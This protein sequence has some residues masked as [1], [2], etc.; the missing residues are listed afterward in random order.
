MS[1]N[2]NENGHKKEIDQVTGVET[3]GHEWDGLKELNNPAPRWWVIVWIICTIW[4]VG[5]WFVYPAWPTKWPW[6]GVNETVEQTGSVHRVTTGAT[7]GSQGWTEYDQLAE[8]Q[9]QIKERQAAYQEKFHKSTYDEILNDPE[10]YAFAVAGGRA[11]FKLNCMVCHGSDAQGSKGYP[12]LSDDDWLWG[13]TLAD[14]EQTVRY[15]IRSGDDEARQSEM[16]SFGKDELL[17]KEEVNDVVDYVLSLSSDKG[18]D[19]KSA[20]ATIFADNC[21]ACHGEQGKG[22]R[23]FGAPNLTDQIWLYGGDRADVY[24]S[25]FN[26]HKGVMPFWHGKLTDDQIRQLTIYVHSLGG[27]EGKGAAVAEV[28][29]TQADAASEEAVQPEENADQATDEATDQGVDQGEGQDADV[30][31]QPAPEE[32][33][34][35]GSTSK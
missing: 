14:I 12:N 24:N 25:V 15:G 23:E 4:A 8:S 27:G 11:E 6:F 28:Q 31:D 20:G 34:T 5:Y 33:E 10:L 29:D 32:A 26:A 19:Q 7:K 30:S 3:T 17:S 1:D 2:H 9:G 16:P 22:G 35:D 13:G 21:A 18:P